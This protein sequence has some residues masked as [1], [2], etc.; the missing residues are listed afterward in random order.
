[1]NIETQI[2]LMS[3]NVR[4]AS[5]LEE[6]LPPLVIA[7]LA[8]VVVLAI[9]EQTRFGFLSWSREFS[10]L[11]SNGAVA[12]GTGLL[13][14]VTWRT[15][16]KMERERELTQ[17][18]VDEMRQ[19]RELTNDM[20]KAQK[21]PLIKQLV[22]DGLD[23][24][25]DR[26]VELR[27]FS[28][29]INNGWHRWHRWDQG[30]LLLDHRP[31]PSLNHCDSDI[32]EDIIAD[33]E[34]N[35]PSL[36]E[37]IRAYQKAHTEYKDQWEKVREALGERIMSTW[38]DEHEVELQDLFAN[39]DRDSQDILDEYA[40]NIATEVLRNPQPKHSSGEYPGQVYQEFRQSLLDLRGQQEF[41]DNID[42]LDEILNELRLHHQNIV[43]RLPEVRKGYLLEYDIYKSELGDD[44]EGNDE[45]SLTT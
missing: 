41:T 35:H 9:I 32:N 45:F 7:T 29:N 12:I 44:Q 18:M 14:A 19:E 6:W 1:M 37:D 20:F 8:I 16:G 33:I 10:N 5:L 13:A 23:E 2:L 17:D 26:L 31:L 15:L 30:T 27:N 22:E 39:D 40:P 3:E 4:N 24:V 36:V 25:D 43:P 28:S 21:K 42:A 38:A 34:L 11:V